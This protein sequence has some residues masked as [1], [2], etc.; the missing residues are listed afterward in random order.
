MEEKEILLSIL[1][2]QRKTNEL[3]QIIASN[4]EQ[5]VREPIEVKIDSQMLGEIYSKNDVTKIPESKS[6]TNHDIFPAK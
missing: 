4:Q 1:E 5:S 6:L 2:E 3:L